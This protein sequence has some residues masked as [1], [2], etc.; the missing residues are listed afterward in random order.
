M[1]RK[2]VLSR[3]NHEKQEHHVMSCPQNKHQ[4]FILSAT[5]E[6]ELVSR[7]KLKAYASASLAFLSLSGLIVMFFIRT[8]FPV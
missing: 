2:Q 7:K 4:P 1:A 8:P 6:E 5:E 3:I